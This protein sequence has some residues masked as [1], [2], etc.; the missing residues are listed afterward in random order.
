MKIL[1]VNYE[2]PPIGGGGGQA[3][4]NLLR[5]YA[6]MEG[7]EVEVLTSGL[8]QG[9]QREEMAEN[10]TIYKVG[11]CKK[12]LHYWRKTEVL[13]WLYKAGREYN[14]LI[15]TNRYDLVHAFFGFPT[16][17]LCYRSRRQ[18]PYF[19]SLRGSDVPG[20]NPRFAMDYKILAPLFRRIWKNASVMV[21]PSQ[22]LRERARRF[23]PTAEIQVI[24]NGVDLE[25]FHPAVSPPDSGHIKLLTVGRLSASKRIEL[26]IEVMEIL[27][28]KMPNLRLTIA[29][30]GGL[31][32]SLKNRVHQKQISEV[33]QFRGRVAN[34]EMPELYRQHDLYVS[35]TFQEGMSNAFLEAMA[36]GLPIITTECE[37]TEELID[38]NGIIIRP[39][40]KEAFAEAIGKLVQDKRTMVK[41]SA[42]A[43]QRAET[44]TWKAAAAQ[45]LQSYNSLMK[46]NR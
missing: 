30:G 2:F 37:G 5:E 35:A 10:I 1:M 26:L 14:K 6:K 25:K 44:F 34:E 23:L 13:V 41:M 40:T 22:G 33:I 15:Q 27:H 45:Y 19:I 32:E 39:P 12:D 20:I 29:G 36:S 43:C 17:W 38:N 46:R 31:G 21:S 8:G 16:G 3:H 9:L 11:V 42:A 18:L 7:L 28:G 4:Q 24:P